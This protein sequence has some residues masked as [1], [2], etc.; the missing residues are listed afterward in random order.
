MQSGN[1]RVR[2]KA[3]GGSRAAVHSTCI[4]VLQQVL[5]GHRHIVLTHT[6]FITNCEHSK[7]LSYGLEWDG[8]GKA[9]DISVAPAQKQC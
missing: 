5:Q 2:L 8:L 7:H 4:R 9:G 6:S 1:E 3:K